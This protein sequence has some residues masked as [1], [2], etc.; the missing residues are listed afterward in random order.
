[1]YEK[2]MFRFAV[3]FLILILIIAPLAAKTK[4]FMGVFLKDLNEKDFEKFGVEGKHGV[5][6]TEVIEDKAAEKAGFKDEDVVIAFDGDKV[7]TLDQLTKM[8]NLHKPGD[9]VQVRI[10]RDKKEKTIKLTLGEKEVPEKKTKAYLGVY[11]ENLDEDDF[12]ELGLKEKYGVEIEDVVED[13]PVDEAGIQEDDVILQINDDKIYTSD[14]I[15]KMLKILKPD[16]KVKIKIFRDGEYKTFDVVLGEKEDYFSL[17]YDQD[18]KVFDFYKDP[19]SVFVYKYEDTDGKH[20]G[21][22]LSA[23]K[24]VKKEGDEEII[25]KKVVIDE[26]FKDSPADKAG[27]KEDDIIL[28]AD[29]K[30]IDSVKDIKKAISKK[31][32]GD[33]IELEIK[34]KKKIK[35]FKVEIAKKKDFDLKSN[36]VEVF[37]EDGD[38]KVWVDGNE[39]HLLDIDHLKDNIDKIKILKK[40]HLEDLDDHI[41]K[42]INVEIEEFGDI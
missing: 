8:I 10:V 14:Q 9:K 7:Y 25:E 5:L 33:K 30:E 3:S 23:E 19:A 13:G 27:L 36:K 15:T 18:S 34:R 35:T 32:V 12:K 40:E 1:M 26:V 31:E 22:L 42:E 29:G 16:Q 28:K 6:I 24:K 17:F 21:V 2:K 38:L 41:Q 39:E 4:A 11:V 37:L 20:I